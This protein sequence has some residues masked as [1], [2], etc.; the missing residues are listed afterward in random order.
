MRN[1]LYP[2]VNESDPLYEWSFLRKTG[3][4]T[5]VDSDRDYTLPDDFSGTILD[6][7]TRYASGSKNP[8]LLKV[9]ESTIDRELAEDSTKGIP[10]YFAIRNLA[11]A[12]TTGQRYELL[13]FPTPGTGAALGE[14]LVLTY[15]YVLLQDVIN[16]TNLY[17]PG[18]ARYSELLLLSCLAAAEERMDDSPSNQ[19]AERFKQQLISAIRSDLQ[20]KT[21]EREG[22]A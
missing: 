3:S 4:I 19:F 10:R 12:P 16:S 7:S 15:R 11:H 13:V 22:K 17:P 6:D 1:W 9:S 8:P 18:G 14:G 5:L 20:I 21:N 2:A